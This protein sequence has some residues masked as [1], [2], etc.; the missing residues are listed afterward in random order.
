MF[1]PPFESSHQ[2]LSNDMYPVQMRTAVQNAKQIQR[3]IQGIKYSLDI[4]QALSGV[5]YLS[6]FDA[7]SGFTQMEFD[8]ESRPITAIHTHHSLHHF[9]HMPFGWR[10]GPPEFQRVMQEILLPYLWVFT[11][12]YID[13][14]VVYSCTFKDHLKHVDQVL[15]VIADSGLTLSPPNAISAIKVS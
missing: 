2:P 11:L 14:V 10:N 12:V 3:W 6:V 15:K 5:Q 8:E 7:L 4:L 13:D 1:L 9:K